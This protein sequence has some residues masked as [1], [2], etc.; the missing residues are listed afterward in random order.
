[1]VRIV[2]AESL[3]DGRW[4]ILVQGM[5]LVNIN[6]S[7]EGKLY[8]QAVINLR[9]FQDEKV[10][11]SE[12]RVTLQNLFIDYVINSESQEQ[13]KAEIQDILDSDLSDEVLLNTIAMSM[14]IDPI[15]RQFLLEAKSIQDLYDRIYQ[16]WDF[17]SKGRNTTEGDQWWPL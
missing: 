13:A 15:E 6:E 9:T 11:T 12:Q 16:L 7:V 10:L 3:P 14:K 5:A 2:R 4:N 17:M 8:R 1:M